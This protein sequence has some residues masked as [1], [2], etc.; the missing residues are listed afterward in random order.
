MKEK[1]IEDVRL[2]CLDNGY[3]KEAMNQICAYL[4]G[5]GIK[6]RKEIIKFLEGR[7]QLSLDEINK[8]E[9][10]AKAESFRS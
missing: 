4:C 2:H 7:R 6:G 3:T 9:A 1:T 5:R 8:A 10:S